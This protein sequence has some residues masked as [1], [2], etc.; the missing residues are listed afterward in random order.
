MFFKQ[1]IVI[2]NFMKKT[3]DLF[4][5]YKYYGWIDFGVVNSNIEFNTVIPFWADSFEFKLSS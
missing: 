3:K 1:N 5:N 4:P 2:H